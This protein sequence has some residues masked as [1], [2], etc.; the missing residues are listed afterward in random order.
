M[1][2]MMKCVS[3]QVVVS[4]VENYIEKLHLQLNG[5]FGRA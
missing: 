2:K 4:D 1:L 5:V 3:Q